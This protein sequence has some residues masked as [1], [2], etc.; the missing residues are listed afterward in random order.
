MV[1]F[2]SIGPGLLL[3]FATKGITVEVD[4]VL[5]QEVAVDAVDTIDVVEVLMPVVLVA[6][7]AV[8]VD[9]GKIEVITVLC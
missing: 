3:G 6:L 7:V 1:I 8:L 2:N 4:T 9:L 5:V